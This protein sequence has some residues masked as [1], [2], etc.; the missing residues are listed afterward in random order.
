MKR[1]KSKALRIAGIALG[2][3]AVIFVILYIIGAIYYNS[4]IFPKTAL[5]EV[6]LSN[7]T[8]EE[9][10]NRLNALLDDYVLT[11]TGRDNLDIK[12]CSKDV[13]LKYELN[14]FGE[15]LIEEQNPFMWVGHLFST[16]VLNDKFDIT[17]DSGL[18]GEYVDTLECMQQENVIKPAD[19]YMSGYEQGKGY[20]IIPEVAGNEI[21]REKFEGVV[22]SALKNIEET[23][24][25]EEKGCYV[26]PQVRSDAQELVEKVSYY[27]SFVSARITYTFGEDQIILDGDKIYEWLIFKKNGKIKIDEA[28]VKAFVDSIGSKYDTIFRGR[29]FKTSYGRDVEIAEGD[30][31]WWMNRAEETKQIINLIKNGEVTD[32]EPVYF[33][34]AAQYGKSDYGNTYVEVNLTA[35]HL[36]VY[37]DGEVVLESDFVSGKNTKNRKTPPGVYGITYKE[38]DATLVGEDYETPVSYWMPFNGS[39]GLHDA[40]W[41]TKFGAGLYKGGGSHGCINLPFYVAEKIYGIVEKGTPVICYYLDGTESTSITTQD[42]K[43]IAQFVVDAIERIGSIEKGRIQTLEKTF[44]RIRASYATLTYNQKKYVTN[45]NKL[46]KAEKKFKE[47]KNSL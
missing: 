7:C 39:I 47:L 36:F 20:S 41:R 22:D 42:D 27:N 15:N 2:G 19:A 40:I 46:E 43:E 8:A 29:T 34:K 9:V 12:I 44:E 26:E 21:D 32:R 11:V 14:G 23:V 13:S 1:G 45:F 18:F 4:H 3:I 33:Q 38:R 17:Y 28:K 25:I 5:S 24:N 30:Y 37:K 6:D 10:E 35:Q 16:T 31:G